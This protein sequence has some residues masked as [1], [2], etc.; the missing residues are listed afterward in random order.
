MEVVLPMGCLEI[1][2]KM[3]SM[4]YKMNNN[5]K[6]ADNFVDGVREHG[7]FVTVSFLLQFI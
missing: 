4:N 1:A 6:K 7:K 3:N 2:E 5:R